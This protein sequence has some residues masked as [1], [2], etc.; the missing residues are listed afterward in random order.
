MDHEIGRELFKDQT[1]IKLKRQVA[2]EIKLYDSKELQIT[3]RRLKQKITS[4]NGSIQFTKPQRNFDKILRKLN[5]EFEPS[6]TIPR[7]GVKGTRKSRSPYRSN[8]NRGKLDSAK[9][10]RSGTI[11]ESKLGK[12]YISPR[13]SRSNSVNTSFSTINNSLINCSLMTTSN[14]P[15]DISGFSIHELTKKNNPDLVVNETNLIEAFKRFNNM[16]FEDA[17]S[18]KFLKRFF[19]EL[20][21]SHIWFEKRVD[22]ED[23]DGDRRSISKFDYGLMVEKMKSTMKVEEISILQELKEEDEKESRKAMDVVKENIDRVDIKMPEEEPRYGSMAKKKLGR[24]VVDKFVEEIPKGGSSQGSQEYSREDLE[25]DVSAIEGIEKS[26]Q[27]DFGIKGVEKLDKS[28]QFTSEDNEISP[29]S[30]A[31]NPLDKSFILESEDSNEDKKI[32]NLDQEPN[33]F[34]G[35]SEDILLSGL[36]TSQKFF[37]SFEFVD[38]STIGS[39]LTSIDNKLQQ[40]NQVKMSERKKARNISLAILSKLESLSQKDIPDMVENSINFVCKILE[41]DPEEESHKPDYQQILEKIGNLRMGRHGLEWPS[42]SKSTLHGSIVKADKQ[43]KESYVIDSKAF[44]IDVSSIRGINDSRAMETP[45]FN[46]SS[47]NPFTPSSVSLMNSN[48]LQKNSERFQKNEADQEPETEYLVT[49]QDEEVEGEAEKEGTR[50]IFNFTKKEEVTNMSLLNISNIE[51][52]LHSGLN[53]NDSMIINKRIGGI[54]QSFVIGNLKNNLGPQEEPTC[55]SFYFNTKNNNEV[56]SLNES[57][58]TIPRENLD[59]LRIYN[60]FWSPRY[61]RTGVSSFPFNC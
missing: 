8:Q 50:P 25:D 9:V 32:Q 47:T 30:S 60:Y 49:F 7:S 18:D 37:K 14:Y 43:R 45:K 27:C 3:L 13:T 56:S 38:S 34:Q 44:K 29:T 15:H 51:N 54:T 22:G 12:H 52:H 17:P 11:Q 1:L 59:D 61:L 42:I 4:L 21:R 46:P 33:C 41:L 10:K 48:L 36:G 53:L 6:K 24:D 58:I 20:K 40:L 55:Q 5:T 26:T 16:N 28:V 57:I 2:D 39:K 23:L 19:D 31:K 35:E